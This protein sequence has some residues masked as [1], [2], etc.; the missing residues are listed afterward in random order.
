M[1]PTTEQITA[2]RFEAATAGDLAMVRICDR[3]IAGS[4]RALR[5]CRRVIAAAIAP[6][7]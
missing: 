2:L 5:E 6:A 7:E 1:N 4:S 3:A